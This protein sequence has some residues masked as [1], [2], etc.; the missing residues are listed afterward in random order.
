MLIVNEDAKHVQNGFPPA[1][2]SAFGDA[3]TIADVI[4][5]PLLI[6]LLKSDLSRLINCI[7]NPHVLTDL[8]LSSFII[9][10]SHNYQIF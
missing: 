10:F 2:K 1:V 8:A 3:L 4:I 7:D 9:F 5:E 6:Q